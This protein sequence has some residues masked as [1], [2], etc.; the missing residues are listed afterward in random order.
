MHRELK[1]VTVFDEELE[2]LVKDM[3][4]TMYAAKGVGLAEAV[5]TAKAYVTAAIAAANRISIGSGHG[6]VHHFHAWW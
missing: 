6:P 2:T 4:A 5:G 1:D 3:V